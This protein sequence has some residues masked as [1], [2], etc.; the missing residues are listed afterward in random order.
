MYS[1]YCEKWTI[2]FRLRRSKSY[3]SR[4]FCEKYRNLIRQH[5]FIFITLRCNFVEYYELHA[6]KI[7]TEK[8]YNSEEWK[9][10]R[11]RKIPVQ[12]GAIELQSTHQIFDFLYP[13]LSFYKRKMSKFDFI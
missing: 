12:N 2:L 7:L 8:S 1:E 13:F 5:F 9:I 10:F 6:L 3:L 4:T 11:S